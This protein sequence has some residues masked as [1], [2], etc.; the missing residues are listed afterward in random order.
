MQDILYQEDD[1]DLDYKWLTDNDW[2]T[3]FIKDSEQ[4]IGRFKWS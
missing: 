2:L 3:C 4:V 1:P